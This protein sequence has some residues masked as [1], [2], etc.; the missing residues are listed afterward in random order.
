M[1]IYLVLEISVREIYG[2]LLFSIFAASKG[3][4]VLIGTSNDLWLYK[5]QK[6]LPAGALVVKNVNIP[7]KSEKMYRAYVA[8]DF[9]IYCHEA[10]ASIL[11]SDFQIFLK[12]YSITKD[13]YFPFKGVF[14]WG[15]RDYS[16]Y[17]KLFSDKK[18]VFH[19][20]GSPRVDLWSDK[21]KSFWKRDYITKMDPYILFVS[22]NS[23]AVGRRH[24][25]KFLAIQRDLELLQ[26]DGNEENLYTVIRKDILMVENI[27]FSL[28]QLA[29]KYPHINFVIRPHPMDNEEHWRDAIG[30]E[31]K[32]IHVIYRDSITP[33]IL[34]ASVL[35][36][37][38]CTSAIE[39]SVQGIPIISF[40]PNES[41]DILGIANECGVKVPNYEELDF[42][43]SSAL[44]EKNTHKRTQESHSLLDPLI[45][46]D[47]K[48]ASEKILEH[49][50]TDS[51]RLAF[52]RIKFSSYLV[53]ILL[54]SIKTCIDVFRN[55]DASNKETMQFNKSEVIVG[56]EKLSVILGV[57]KPRIRFIST[58]SVL[59]D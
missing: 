37:N 42:A 47:S 31:Y 29:K 3:H 52:N 25:T 44:K 43:I 30:G 13:Q 16:E 10:E 51:S 11:W 41:S 21:L 9:D 35:L 50:E 17:I 7:F 58:T 12:E 39:A 24:W 28:R 34:G 27:V 48:L 18:N 8:S 40:V 14:C 53:I 15:D 33:W 49:I 5:R 59:I 19:V 32:N 45:S 55:I 2:H 46:I 6:L 36:H 1:I 20:T 26:I 38:S 57:P 54:K 23:W 22:N 56:V 4:Q